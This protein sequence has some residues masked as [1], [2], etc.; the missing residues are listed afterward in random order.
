MLRIKVK[1]AEL[2]FTYE[3][4]VSLHNGY[5]QHNLEARTVAVKQILNECVL[6]TEKIIQA[7]QKLKEHE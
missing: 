7:K 3:D 1:T 6:A 2:V 4:N 5:L